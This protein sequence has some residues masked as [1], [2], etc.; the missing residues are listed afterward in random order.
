MKDSAA[1][2]GENGKPLAK[3]TMG[4]EEKIGLPN[5]SSVNIS[6]WVTR[7]VEDEPEAIAAGLRECVQAVEEV[8]SEE[9]VSVLALRDA[10]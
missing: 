3:V 7:Y 5:Y 4:A 1:V 6:G 9:R 2:I 8:I 10:K